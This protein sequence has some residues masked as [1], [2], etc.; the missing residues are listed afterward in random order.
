[1]TMTEYWHVDVFRPG[2]LKLQLVGFRKEL[3][4]LEHLNECKFQVLPLLL[5]PLTPSD[6]SPALIGCCGRGEF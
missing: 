3:T 4:E 5:S 2:L 6:Y 1:M